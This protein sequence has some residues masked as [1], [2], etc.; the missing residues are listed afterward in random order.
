[1]GPNQDRHRAFGVAGVVAFTLGSVRA[2]TLTVTTAEPPAV[3]TAPPVPPLDPGQSHTLGCCRRS[4]ACP[5][6]DITT[7]SIGTC[8]ETRR[9]ACGIAIADTIVGGAKCDTF[10][11]ARCGDA[12][13]PRASKARFKTAVLEE[14]NLP[15]TSLCLSDLKVKDASS[16]EGHQMAGG[17]T[18]RD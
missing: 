12:P 7:V 15:R 3:F 13:G 10:P 17:H 1:M 18:G 4:N 14:L 5:D 16:G 8:S 11:N 6:L 2:S 9:P